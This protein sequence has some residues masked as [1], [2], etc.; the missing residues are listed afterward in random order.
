MGHSA[1]FAAGSCSIKQQVRESPPGS[2]P[3]DAAHSISR[4]GAG[5][6]SAARPVWMMH[7][8]RLATVSSQSPLDKLSQDLMH[9]CPLSPSL[10]LVL[11]PVLPASVLEHG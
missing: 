7:G 11:T 10:P 3:R 6:S 1:T 8:C 2:H 9:I 4:L 5:S